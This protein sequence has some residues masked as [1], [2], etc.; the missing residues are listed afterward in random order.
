MAVCLLYPLYTLGL[1]P[2]PGLVGHRVVVALTVAIGVVVGWSSLVAGEVL[3]PVAVWVS[4]APVYLSNLVAAKP[5]TP[6]QA[7]RLTAAGHVGYP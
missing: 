5:E 3:A 6:N 4:V 1:Q 7:L 2:M